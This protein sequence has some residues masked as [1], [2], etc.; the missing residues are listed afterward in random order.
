MNVSRLQA[1]ERERETEKE[2]ERESR[3]ESVKDD[4][5]EEGEHPDIRR[6]AIASF[7]RSVDLT[8]EKGKSEGYEEARI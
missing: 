1:H 7:S 4:G 6:R 3:H 5:G 8:L 2:K